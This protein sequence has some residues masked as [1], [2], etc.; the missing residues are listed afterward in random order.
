MFANS[1]LTEVSRKFRS[2]SSIGGM[3]C[4]YHCASP[5]LYPSHTL[6]YALSAY[7]LYADRESGGQAVNVGSQII[8][9]Q[10][11]LTLVDRFKKIFSN[12]SSHDT[13]DSNM[14]K[15]FKKAFSRENV[16]VHFVG[17]W[18]VVHINCHN[19]KTK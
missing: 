4:R 16:K 8:D 14:A 1:A 6:I 13:P 17:A 3:R 12:E 19:R 7:E 15:R 11:R 5:D 9:S 18:C 10:K 2:A